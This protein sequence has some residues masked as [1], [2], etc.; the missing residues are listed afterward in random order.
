MLKP[1]T[2][3]D[4]EKLLGEI[5]QD[6]EVVKNLNDTLVIVGDSPTEPKKQYKKSKEL[7]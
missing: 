3:E 4:V 1:I 6:Q 5:K 7:N 2:H